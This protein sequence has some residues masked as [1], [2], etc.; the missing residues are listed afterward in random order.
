MTNT[1]E[2]FY[3]TMTNLIHPAVLGTILVNLIDLLISRKLFASGIFPPIASFALVWYFIVD[4]WVTMTTFESAPSDYNLWLFVLDI[5][6]L[7]TLFASFYALWI[8]KSDT[9]FFATVVFLIILFG[10][11]NGV[12]GFFNL[13]DKFSKIL[14]LAG[15]ICI[16]PL[17]VSF[18]PEFILLNYAIKYT[19]LTAIML[20]LSWYTKF[21]LADLAE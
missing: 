7:V 16:S 21:T 9:Y 11:W 14:I 10:C 12:I 18:W 3:R 17:V 6:I 8:A 2:I 15:L 13:R 1:K 5:I 4:Y 19:C 20:I